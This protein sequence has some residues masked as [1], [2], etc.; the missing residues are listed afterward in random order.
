MSHV[1]IARIFSKSQSPYI[2]GKLKIFLCPKAS[3]NITKYEEILWRKC[4]EFFRSPRNMK[5]WRKYEGTWRKYVGIMW[6]IRRTLSMY[7][8]WDLEKF[9]ARPLIYGLG[10]GGA[11]SRKRYLRENTWNMS[12]P[13]SLIWGMPIA[14]PNKR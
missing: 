12:K 4:E 2:G 13:I 5:K 8:P 1:Q 7:G 3:G 14:V 10:R 9:R 6:K 11:I